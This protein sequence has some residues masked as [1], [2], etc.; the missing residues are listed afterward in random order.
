MARHDTPTPFS[1]AL[2]LATATA[3]GS[4]SP[5]QTLRAQDLGGGDGEHARA[6]AD[7]DHALRPAALEQA[8][9]MQQA[10]PRRA[11]MA[12]AEGEP[13]LDLDRHVVHPDAR[14]IVGAV[15]EKAPRPNGFKAGKRIGDPVALLGQAEDR[16]AG[17]R[18]VRGQGDQRPDRRLVRL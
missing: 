11:V 12:G 15:Y 3:T 6:A 18:L 8:V 1:R 9:E 16:G 17:G 14:T 13:G 7:V 5:S 2:A 4:M 10:A